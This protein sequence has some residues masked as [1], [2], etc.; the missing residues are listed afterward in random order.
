MTSV[1]TRLACAQVVLK[2]SAFL[3]TPAHETVGTLL[4]HIKQ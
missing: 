2:S 1:G 4:F 3:I